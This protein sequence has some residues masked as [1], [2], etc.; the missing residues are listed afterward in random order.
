MKECTKEE[1]EHPAAKNGW[2]NS[3]NVETFPISNA[4]LGKFNCYR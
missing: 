1:N 4:L 3:A 2:K